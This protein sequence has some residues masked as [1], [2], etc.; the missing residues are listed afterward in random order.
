VVPILL[1][2][3]VPGASQNQERYND[4]MAGGYEVRARDGDL[5]TS[6]N[7]LFGKES[8]GRKSKPEERRV[9]YRHKRRDDG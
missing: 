4:E 2:R 9:G 3:D 5:S 7:C 6:G 1:L 8:K